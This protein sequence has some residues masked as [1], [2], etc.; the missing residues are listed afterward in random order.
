MTTKN[1]IIALI[2]KRNEGYSSD[3][4]RWNYE[5]SKGSWSNKEI[6]NVKGFQVAK[7]LSAMSM[8][9]EPMVARVYIINE[10]EVNIEI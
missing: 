8:F 10:G 2:K 5:V 1:A 9:I 6:I 3:S 7:A 4:I